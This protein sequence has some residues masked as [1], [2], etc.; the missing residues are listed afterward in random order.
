MKDKNLLGLTHELSKT[1]LEKMRFNHSYWEKNAT[2]FNQDHK[3]SWGDINIINMEI[4]NIRNFLK[5]HD[6]VLDAGCSNGY[7]T[8]RIARGKK[9]QIRAFDYSIKSIRHA[10]EMLKKSR[11]DIFFYHANIIN[12]PEGDGVFDKVYTIRV[13]I[14]LLSWE[15]QKA[16]IMEL[17]R[18]LKPGGLLLL[19]EA[20]SG[21]LKKINKLR[22]TA[23]LPELTMQDFNLYLD[24]KKFETF[25]QKNFN[26]VAIKRF[27]SIYYVASRFFRYLT[28]KKE[29]EDTY[30]N[31]FNNYFAKFDETN[32]SGDF[33]VQKLYVLEKK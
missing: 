20:F 24:E 15:M 19:S 5:S 14:N 11:E 7:S 33:G 9:I 12:I 30:I 31:S 10:K 32:H 4:K 17:H 3:V 23:G 6:K 26:I 29:E 16:A 25:I 21:S 28:M 22:T 18:V 8:I 2:M 1:D 27:S 13:I